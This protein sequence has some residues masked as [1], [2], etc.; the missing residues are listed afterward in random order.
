MDPSDALIGRT[1]AG[2]ILIEVLVGRGAMGSVYRGRHLTLEES[3]AVKVM[4]PEYTTDPAFAERFRRE[5][6]TMVRLKH[7]NSVR[8]LDFGQE[9]DGLLYLAME[10]LDGRDLGA[11][12][13]TEWPLAPARIAHLLRQALGALQAAHDADVIHRDL[14]PENILVVSGRDEDGAP[15]EIAKVCD[16]GIAKIRD[17]RA[18]VRPPPADSPATRPQRLTSAGFVVG[19]PEYM[20]PEQGRAESL[21]ARSDV[22]SVGVILYE[23]LTGRIPFEAET[24]VGIIMRHVSDAV[25]PPSKLVPGV[26]PVLESICLRALEKDPAKRFAS[27]RE[28]RTALRVVDDM[29]PPTARAPITVKRGAGTETVLHVDAGMNPSD[30]DAPTDAASAASAAETSSGSHSSQRSH[31]SRRILA[32]ALA[33]AALGAFAS[34]RFAGGSAP[35]LRAAAFPPPSAIAL[36]ELASSA[37]APTRSDPPPPLPVVPV[38]TKSLSTPILRPDL[39]QPLRLAPSTSAPL[40]ADPPQPPPSSAPPVASTP[41]ASASATAMAPPPTPP[42]P[43]PA[44]PPFDIATARVA[45]AGVGSVE[46]VLKSAVSSSLARTTGDM[47]ACYRAELSRASTAESG[48]GGLHLETDDSGVVT[49]AS[50]RVP[51][52]SSIARCVERAVIGSRF[53]GVDTGS[54]SADVSLIFEV[55]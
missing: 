49:S 23:L 47:T 8:V 1:I 45:I 4:H 41:P 18:S 32:G 26:D 54:A 10:Y 37:P 38:D 14:K 21:D 16:F 36:T 7:P 13:R 51:F 9:P 19:T 6:T 34:L 50:A 25:I 2:K 11:V 31:R 27:A 15:S 39:P 53:A 29:A 3:V 48:R 24:A 30:R 52:S 5:A 44:P 12:I 17:A 20:S 43:M 35:A 40:P 55:H 22:Y 28:M 33:V 42:P 46:G